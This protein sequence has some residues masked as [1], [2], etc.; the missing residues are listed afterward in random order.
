MPNAGTQADS[1]WITSV[2]DPDKE[3]VCIIEAGGSTWFAPVDDVC[4]TALDLVT[5]AAY[6]DVLIT[7][8]TVLDLPGSTISKF[9]ADLLREAKIVQLGCPSTI[10]LHPA[11]SSKHK[12]AVVIMRHGQF[13]GIVSAAEARKMALRWLQAAEASG[14]DRN[15]TEAMRGARVADDVIEKVFGYLRELRR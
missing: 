14:S 9:G 6:A 7:L 1:I 11:G 5:A 15:V 8:V 4:Q 3:P 12:E 2:R 13:E 10:T